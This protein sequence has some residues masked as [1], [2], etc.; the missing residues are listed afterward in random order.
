LTFSSGID[1][2]RLLPALPRAAL[3]L[4]CRSAKGA[5]VTARIRTRIVICL[6]VLAFAIPVE[7]I[8]LQALSEQEEQLAVA[9]WVAD[10]SSEDLQAVTTQIESYP[11]LYRKEIMRSLVP[12]RRSE[13]WRAFIQRYLASHPELDENARRLLGEAIDLAG[14]EMFSR[15]TVTPEMAARAAAIGEQLSA[16]IGKDSARDVLHRLG[17]RDGTFASLEPVHMQLSNFV[18]RL[19]IANAANGEDCNCSTSFGCEVGYE[20]SS[21]TGCTPVEE[22]P[23]CGWFWSETCDGDCRRPNLN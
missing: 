11:F 14:P 7:T 18:R 21:S 5:T 10:L 9:S 8:L 20:C 16:I 1:R 6:V 3:H 2:V 22:W 15:A 4:P 17:P 13:V 12:A 23:M 19:M